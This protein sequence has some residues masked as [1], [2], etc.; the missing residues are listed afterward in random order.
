VRRY[1]IIATKA[2]RK[3]VK[4]LAKSGFKLSKL[5]SVI[6]ILSRG[7][8]LPSQYRDHVLR[9]ELKHVRE[10]HIA[11]DWLLSYTKYD[12]KLILVLVRTGTHRDVVG[13]E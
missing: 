4:R 5:E 3:D 13:I 2:Y 11:P 12:E 10:C 7:K 1:E 9:S 6:D 8:A